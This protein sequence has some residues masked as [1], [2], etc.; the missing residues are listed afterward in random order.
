MTPFESALAQGAKKLM[1][2]RRRRDEEERKKREQQEAALVQRWLGVQVAVDAVLA[3]LAPFRLPLERPES[4]DTTCDN[5]TVTVR[6]PE[7][8]GILL[9]LSLATG[10]A[11]QVLDWQ[12]L[13]QKNG[14]SHRYRVPY[15]EK[16]VSSAGG[17][18]ILWD[19]NGAKVLRTSDL[20]LALAFAREAHEKERELAEEIAE[21][22]GN[23]PP[24]STLEDA[25]RGWLQKELSH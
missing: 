23:L 4:F 13:V 17:E 24:Q 1:D 11:W 12:D 7:C 9:R 10:K 3:D 18:F 8:S 21:R 14:R 15:P 25:L 20:Q 16:K 2:A 6:F 5:A 19:A 22:A